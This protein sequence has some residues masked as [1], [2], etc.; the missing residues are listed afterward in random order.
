MADWYAR[1]VFPVA[2]PSAALE[3][4]CNSLGFT[5]DWRFDEDGE[6]LA[7]QI[8]RD[9]CEVILRRLPGKAG[10]GLVFLSLEPEQL[11]LLREE[12]EAGGVD[13]EDSWWGYRLMEVPDPDGNRLQFAYPED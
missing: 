13:I 7:A 10:T 2:D 6:V 8:S 11:G 3:F 1:P 5:E 9:G 12:Y 4:Y